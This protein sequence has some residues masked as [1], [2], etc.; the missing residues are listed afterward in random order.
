MVMSNSHHTPPMQPKLAR[1]YRLPD[2]PALKTC[3]MLEVFETLARRRAQASFA[4]TT[5]PVWRSTVHRPARRKPAPL[6]AGAAGR[7]GSTA[8]K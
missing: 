7:L 4:I 6:T 8:G 1:P 2:A 3:G 5:P